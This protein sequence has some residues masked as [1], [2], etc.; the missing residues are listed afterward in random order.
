MDDETSLPVASYTDSDERFAVN[1]E[2]EMRTEPW[3]GFGRALRA[4]EGV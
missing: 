2:P 1:D 3:Q 4:R